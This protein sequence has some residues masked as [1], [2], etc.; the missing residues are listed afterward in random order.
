MSYGVVG[1]HYP[2]LRVIRDAQKFREIHVHDKNMENLICFKHVKTQPSVADMTLNMNGPRTIATFMHNH[3]ESKR[4]MH[5]LIE[6]CD[7]E[8]TILNLSN[9]H[10]EVSKSYSSM[11]EKNG[12]HYMSAGM[13]NDTLMV[14]GKKDIVDA[15]ELFFRTF[16]RD[17][18]HIGEDPGSGHFAKMIHENME[19]ALFQAYA[20]TLSYCNQEKTITYILEDAK[21]SD[22]NG[23]ILKTTIDRLFSS[24]Q[25]EDVAHINTNSIWCSK[26]A[27]DACIPTPVLQTS[28]N[29]RMTSRYMKMI[30]TKQPFNR[31]F[32][33]DVALNTL[34]FMYAM[35]YYEGTQLSPGIKACIQGSSLECNAFNTEPF[36]IMHDTIK[37]AR[38]FV[39][40]CAH[41]GIP[42]PIAQAAVCQYD[43]LYQTKTSMNFIASLPI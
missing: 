41:A 20:D 29:A 33:R 11:C 16:A 17:I 43:F 34:R 38:T 4:T 9:E 24:H 3:E 15:H 26:Y 5:Q 19:C 39:M 28:L 18:V 13:S 1:L 12:I 23:P 21:N 27:L 31:F 30:E 25:Y 8:D 7:K 37:Y 42:C 2:G 40:H 10:Y 32:D 6:W 35:I 36:D 14:G 22:I